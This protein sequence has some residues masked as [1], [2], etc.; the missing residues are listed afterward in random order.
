MEATCLFVHGDHIG[1]ARFGTQMVEALE[2]AGVA[3]YD[4]FEGPDTPP[5][6]NEASTRGAKDTNVVMWFAVPN[7][8][9][10]W[11]EGQMSV[12][13]TMWESNKLPETM[14]EN[15]DEFATVVVPSEQN[16]ELFGRYHPNVHTVP[17]GINPDVWHYQQRPEPTQFFD[18]LIGGS[19]GRKG[20]D[21]A[22][23]A[24]L[25]GFPK[26]SWGR[27]QP[28]PRLVMKS[29]KPSLDFGADRVMQING[30]IPPEV[31]VGLYAS[32]HCYIQPSRGEG[33]GLQPLQA[34]AQGM[35][36]I[37]TG[38]HGHEAFAH[39][40]YPIGWDMA[41]AG[42]FAAGDA[43]EWWE[44][45]LD[46]LIDQMRFVYERYDGCVEDMKTSAQIVARDFTWA[47]SAERLIDVVGRD[48]LSTPYENSRVWHEPFLKRFPTI[49]NKDMTCDVA[50]TQYRFVRGE[51]T[52]VVA[53]VKRL[54]WEG[55]HLDPACLDASQ[56]DDLG[57][58]EQQTAALGAYIDRY[59]YCQSC[60]H[61]LNV[62]E[63]RADE[64]YAQLERDAAEAGR[65]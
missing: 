16:R 57:L 60:G 24:F 9:R 65:P 20:V 44:P 4:H 26:G 21:I 46:E 22:Y 1:Y 54:L 8:C 3:I 43:G 58:N 10:G 30:F 62:G 31:E 45:R 5:H 32:S 17:L 39:L 63:T 53:D 19:G 61:K 51:K 34:L 40:G 13:F 33:F 56:P 64:I 52:Y 29:P 14:R 50:G 41:P 48:N 37:L 2:Q 49:T 59:S 12:I 35:P 27:E 55:G 47:R 7:H 36:T 38:A 23:K 18:F 15:L 42:Y 6:L 11:W 25:K 28:I